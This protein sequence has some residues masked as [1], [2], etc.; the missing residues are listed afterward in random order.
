[1]NAT[2]A[3][4][5]S[6]WQSW[7]GRRLRW[8]AGAL[9]GSALVELCIDDIVFER[10]AAGSRGEADFAQS[11]SGCAEMEFSLRAADGGALGPP[12]RILHGRAAAAGVD[13][14]TG[15]VRR[16]RLPP[17]AT[18]EPDGPP[19]AAASIVVPIYNSPQCVERCIASVL[20]WT[21]GPAR[22]ILIDD[23]S[24]DPGVADV[25][26]RHATRPGVVVH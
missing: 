26:A 14:W 9:R 16:M 8:D 23:A 15:P 1:M 18:R 25:L 11:P 22:L 7:D 21:Q 2:V 17:A 5:A 13:A 12:W 6:P 24:D 19:A 20:R 10:F 3:Q 4:A